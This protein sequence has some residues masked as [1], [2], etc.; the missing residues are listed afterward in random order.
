M[1]FTQGGLQLTAEKKQ[2]LIAFL[3]TLTDEEFVTDER[4]TDPGAPQ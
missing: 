4:F 1:K 2:Q 3:H